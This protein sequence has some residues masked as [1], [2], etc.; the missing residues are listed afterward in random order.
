MKDILRQAPFDLDEEQVEWVCNTIDGLTLREKIGQ[1]INLQI[2]PGDEEAIELVERHQLGAVTVINFSDPDAC[3]SVI[4][5]ARKASRIRPLVSADLEGGVTSGH[6]TTTFPNQ[7]GCAAAACLD[8]Y[9]EALRM[10]SA[11]LASLGVNWTFSPVLD[12]NQ[13]FQSAIVGTR[14]YGSNPDLIA[15]LAGLHIQVFQDHG[16]ATTAKHWPGE[17]FDDRDQH[18]VTTINPMTVEEWT[19]VFGQLYARAIDA[20][21]LS[22][23]SAHIAFPDYLRRAGLSSIEL[24]RPASISRHLNQTLLREQLQFNGLIVSDATLMGGL[25]SW[26]S[27]R[28]WL[29]EVIE[30]GCDMILFSPSVDT[31]IETL[32]EAAGSGALSQQR[33]D[34][35]LA[36]VL[37][38]KA[39]MN[40]H[41]AEAAAPVDAGLIG[42]PAHKAVMARLSDLSPTLV[43]DVHGI[44]PLDHKVRKI[45]MFKEENV[46]PLGGDESFRIQLDRLLA[47]EGFEVHV[48]DP[49]TDDLS[50]CKAHDLILYV[51]AQESQLMKSRLFIDW[52]RLH[53]GTMPGMSRLW[54]DTPTVFISFGHPYY[55]Y[56]APRVP[57]LINAYTPTP[58]IQRAVVDK[59]LGRSRFTGKS[60]VD[61]FCGLAD[62]HF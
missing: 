34:A 6:L 25:E 58:D 35:A 61:A 9:G 40:L 41:R 42:S 59:L 55:L 23:M 15:Q 21:V 27:R 1:L 16:I 51:F 13:K 39:R 22:V 62:A 29:P 19:A 12:V 32:L 38:L 43:K 30:N 37:G 8:T 49:Q 26:G 33:I 47:A 14:S 60:P 3:R 36:R 31:D 57:C 17:G 24:Y 44:V 5:A 4:D 7:L 56:D 50:I 46:H 54:W 52:A 2:L 18:L 20:G 45:L 10:L 53:G 28:Q 11:E 48:F